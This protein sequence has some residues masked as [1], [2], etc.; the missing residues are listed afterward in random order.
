[1][2]LVT[3]A[4]KYQEISQYEVDTNLVHS[5]ISIILLYYESRIVVEVPFRLGK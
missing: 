1:M 4:P 5:L 2:H 3:D